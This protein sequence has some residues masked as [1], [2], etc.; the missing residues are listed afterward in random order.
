MRAL[1]PP[2]LLGVLLLAFD[3]AAVQAASLSVAPTRVE[4]GQDARSATITL[5]NQG[6]ST[7]TVQVQTFAWAHSTA[8]EALET[9][10]DLIAVPPVF[11]LEPD[12]KQ[13]IRVALRAR[14]DAT[15]EH[16]YRLL[17]TEV[18]I[19]PPDSKA[20]VR[21]ALRLSLPVFVAAPGALPEPAWS[22]RRL[23]GKPILEL[24]NRGRAHLRVR[25]VALHARGSAEPVQV[26]ETPIYVLPGQAHGW[27]LDGAALA[28]AMLKLR[29]ETD[30]GPLEAELVLPPR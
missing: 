2:L 16:A 8:S 28:H 20:A 30:L 22:A 23:D 24:A 10:R 9:T 5:E 27:P 26:I 4:L 19:A 7:V 1:L 29:A 17:I 15:R 11:S 12:A 14:P 13:I 25:R 3:E 21:F 6:D 18:P